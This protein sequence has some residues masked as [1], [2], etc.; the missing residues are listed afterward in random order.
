[1]DDTEE[2]KENRPEKE[3]DK[4]KLHQYPEPEDHNMILKE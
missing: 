4:K 2:K 3:K 1:M